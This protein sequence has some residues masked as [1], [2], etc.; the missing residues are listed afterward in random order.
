MKVKLCMW[1]M[2][3]LLVI[4]I[5][6]VAATTAIG[7]DGEF[8][9]YEPPD[10]CA[11]ASCPRPLCANPVIPEG[12]CCPSCENSL[13]QFKGCVQFLGQPGS[14][15]VQW[16]PDGCSTCT[17]ADNRTLCYALGCPPVYPSSTDL[18]FGRPHITSPTECCDVCDFGVPENECD[19]V[20]NWSTT[21]QLG[22]EE[23]GSGCDVTL[24]F[25]FCDKRGFMDDQGRRF[26]CK[27]VFRQRSVKLGDDSDSVTGSCSP[28]TG[29]AYKDVVRCVPER[30]DDLDV[31]C[32][33]YVD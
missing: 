17:C 27:P 8:Y 13:C 15:T 28:L 1:K 18:C 32:D 23:T 10:D 24:T 11:L 22:R 16:K 21:Y 33:I 7:D 29:L 5:L 2:K 20:P 6:L 30:D 19:V 14:K 3:A 4:H 25:H 26:R 12:E 9:R 31:G